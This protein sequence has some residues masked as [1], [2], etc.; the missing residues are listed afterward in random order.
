M[1]QQEIMACSDPDRRQRLLS[2][3]NELWIYWKDMAPEGEGLSVDLA[4]AKVRDEELAGLL[5]CFPDGDDRDL[6]AHAVAFNCDV[7]CTRDQ[8]TILN[9]L[10]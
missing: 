6:I 9:R 10:K 5:G 2:W 4:D 8:R 7:F 3:L 1:T